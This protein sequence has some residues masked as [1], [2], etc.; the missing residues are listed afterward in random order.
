MFESLE[1]IVEP[2]QIKIKKRKRKLTGDFGVPNTLF[3]TETRLRQDNSRLEDGTPISLGLEILRP[4]DI[5][6][7]IKFS[8]DP[9]Y[10]VSAL[11]NDRLSG[12][13][14]GGDLKSLPTQGSFLKKLM[15]QTDFKHQKLAEQALPS[16]ESNQQVDKLI[17]ENLH[18]FQ[19]E[20]PYGQNQKTGKPNKKPGR[21][22]KPHLE[23]R[24]SFGNEPFENSVPF[25]RGNI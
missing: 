10:P 22:T 17:E 3:E 12:V 7:K 8:F 23:R 5:T 14:K 20:F 21:Q 25:N 24:S 16:K 13:R 4:L 15:S 11:A 9:H 6:K 2:N 18:K 1:N 19:K